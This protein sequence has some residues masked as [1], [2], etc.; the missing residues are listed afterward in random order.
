[1]QLL[2]D[3]IATEEENRGGNNTQKDFCVESGMHG[4]EIRLATSLV[5]QLW[6]SIV[7]VVHKLESHDI[8]SNNLCCQINYK[9]SCLIVNPGHYNI[10]YGNADTTLRAR[11]E[12]AVILS[13]TTMTLNDLW[14]EWEF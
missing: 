12:K 6:H 13:N 1:M 10:G 9:F 14:I 4:K 8:N 11:Q 2:M 7:Y 3:V 5:V